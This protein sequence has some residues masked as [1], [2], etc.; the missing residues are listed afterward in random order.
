[1]HWFFSNYPEIRINR[2]KNWVIFTVHRNKQFNNIT[3]CW[4]LNFYRPPLY[5]DFTQKRATTSFKITR[6]NYVLIQHR[7]LTTNFKE[8][9]AVSKENFVFPKVNKKEGTLSVWDEHV[10]TRYLLISVSCTVY[11]Y[12]SLTIL[13]APFSWMPQWSAP[14]QNMNL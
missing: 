2:K 10:R 6:Q 12:C 13:Q 4:L 14:I 8:R 7:N 3:P 1:M 9:V 11:F 5:E